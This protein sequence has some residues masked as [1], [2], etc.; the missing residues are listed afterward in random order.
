MGYYN[1][2]NGFMNNNNS[3]SGMSGLYSLMSDYSSI[4]NGSY[5]KL[6]NAYYET[7]EK[8]SSSKTENQNTT[9]KTTIDSTKKDSVL[10]GIKSSVS[11]MASDVKDFRKKGSEVSEKAVEKFASD[12]NKL[13]DSVSKTSNSSVNSKLTDLKDYVN[14]Q[15]KKLDEVGIKVGSD[16]KLSV[17]KEKFAKASSDQLASLFQGGASFA[18]MVSLK[19]DSIGAEA[20]LQALRTTSLYDGTGSYQMMNTTSIFN[21]LM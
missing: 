14:L 12:Y 20:T 17:D 1:F 5:R 10:D 9:K 19:A 7:E 3:F 21:G 16:S 8:T 2:F 4:Q 13:L 15:K 11:A 6:L 18:S